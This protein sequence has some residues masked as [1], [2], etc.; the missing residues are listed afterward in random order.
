MAGSHRQS[1]SRRSLLQAGVLGA[2]GLTLSDAL[3]FADAAPTHKTTADSVL[4]LNLA[5][6]PAHLDT[7]DMKDNLPA[8]TRSEFQ[9]ISSKLPGLK[10]CEHL[11]KLAT[12]IDR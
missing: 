4:F 6:G 1:V 10:I 12:V 9:A 8:E 7:L 5:G 2:V 11:P 3:R